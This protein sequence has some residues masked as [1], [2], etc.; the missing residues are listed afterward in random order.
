[1]QEVTLPRSA[2]GSL[3]RWLVPAG[4]LVLILIAGLA[5]LLIGRESVWNLFFLICLYITLGQS[6]NIRA[7]FAG[8]T[9]LGH[10][11]FFGIGALVTRILWLNGVPFGLAFLPGGLAAV[12]FAML[13]GVPTFRLRGAYFSIGTLGI[14]EV[15][16]IAVSQNLPLISTMS[17]RQIAGYD[18]PTRYYAALALALATMAAAYLL[19]RSSWALGILAVRED[20]A[21][22]QASGVNVLGHKL[23][24]L[25][26]SSF[27]AGLAGSMF[28]FQQ[29]SYYPS[30]PFDSTWTFDALLVAFIG[31]L[32]TLGG[33]VIG[34]FF[35]IPVHQLLAVRLVEFHQVIFGV[36]FILI[37]L[38]FPGGLVE[39][40]SRL[41]RTRWGELVKK[42]PKRIKRT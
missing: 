24:A 20:E 17:A 1:M 36:L 26:I 2:R 29:I 27:F 21:A 11:A 12:A 10:A 34:A 4:A 19:L 33:P 32:G 13:I 5:P 30:E 38:A 7:G 16:R 9:S 8:Q 40:W 41:K 14:A 42:R 22:A 18:L 39:A 23:L 25:A 15:L 37:V 6:W 3:R 35:Y 31:G 28:A